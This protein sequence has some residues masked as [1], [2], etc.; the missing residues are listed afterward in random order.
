MRAISEGL[1][2]AQTGTKMALALVATLYGLLVANF[3]IAP[4]AEACSKQIEKERFQ[5]ELAVQAVILAA[6]NESLLKSQE[7]LNSY[8]SRKDRV[9]ILAEVMQEG[10][11]A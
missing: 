9:N 4:F 11:S 3:M 2:P 5:G 10:I 7:L 8:I 6:D 1:D